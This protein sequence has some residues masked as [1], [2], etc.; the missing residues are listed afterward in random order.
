M[1]SSTIAKRT[2]ALIPSGLSN[3]PWMPTPHKN[4]LRIKSSRGGL[5]KTAGRCGRGH[6]HAGPP[7]ASRARAQVR[8]AEL[9]HQAG[10]SHGGREP[11]VIQEP[12]AGSKL[13]AGWRVNKDGP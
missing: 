7:A 13:T 11:R 2:T 5:G 1:R 4:G 8:P 12:R 10:G 3:R 9:A 6:R